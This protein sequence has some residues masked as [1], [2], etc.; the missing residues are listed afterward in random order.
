MPERAINVSTRQV[1]SKRFTPHGEANFLYADDDLLIVNATGPFNL[2]F[3]ENL[4]VVEYS[5]MLEMSQRY[6]TWYALAT[7]SVSM[8]M[9]PET[10]QRYAQHRKKMGEAGL[11]PKAIA[12]VMAPDV[13]G[14]GLMHPHLAQ[15]YEEAGV[16]FAD[17]TEEQEARAWLMQIKRG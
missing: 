6:P 3:I 7:I 11:N 13:E 5:L 8:M 2:E 1:Q 4:E 12:F 14:R 9:T 17:F 10:V 15:L 16:Q